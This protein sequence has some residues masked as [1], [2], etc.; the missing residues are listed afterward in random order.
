MQ[1]KRFSAR[2]SGWFGGR[3][4]ESELSEE[5]RSHIAIQTEENLAGGMSAAEARR[6]A[7][8]AFGSVALA[9]ETSREAWRFPRVDSFAADLKF[10]C[11]MLWKAPGFTVVALL[12]LALG[13]AANTALFTVVNGVLL[14][15]L[16]FPHPEQL[17]TLDASKPN[18]PRG[19]ISYPNFVDWQSRNRTFSAMALS[20]GTSFTFSA[21]GEPERLRG[22]WITADYFSLLGVQPVIGRNLMEGEDTIGGP[23]IALISEALWRRKLGASAEVLGSVITLDGGRYSVVG[24][25]PASFE[26]MQVNFAPPEVYLPMGTWPTGALRLR[27]AGLGLHGIGRLKPGVTIEQARRDMERVTR[28]LSAEFPDVDRGLGATLLPLQE[29]L[30]GGVRATL[31]FLF[32]AVGFVLLIACVNVASLMLARSAARTREFAVR[33]ALGASRSRVIRQLLTEALLLAVAGG[34]LGVAFASWLTRAAM[35]LLPQA[36]PRMQQVRMDGYVLAFAAAASGV[37]AVLFGLGPAFRMAAPPMQ[38][39]L[40]TGRGSGGR[41]LRT[42]RGLIVVEVATALLLLVGAGLSLR[43]LMRL[44]KVDPGFNSQ[45]VLLLNVDLPPA[46]RTAPDAAVYAAWRDIHRSLNSTPGVTAASL[47]DGS[48][49]FGGDDE[50]L[51]WHG[52]EPHP[53]SASEMNWALRYDVTPEYLRT[54]GLPLL[55]GR[56]FTPQEDRKSPITVVVDDVFAATFFPGQDAIGK[57]IQWDGLYGPGQESAKPLREAEIVGVVGH[58]KHWGLDTDDKQQLRAQAYLNIWQTEQHG[59]SSNYGITLRTASAP[60]SVIPALRQ[61]LRQVNGEAVVYGFRT[62]DNVIEQSLRTRRFT[63]VLLA[64]FAAIALLL[65]AIGIYGVISYLVRERTQEIGVRMALGAQRSTVLRMVLGEG[66]RL[67]GLG[68]L[69]GIVAA[70]PGAQAIRAQLFGTSPADPLTFV[71]VTGILLAVALAASFIPAYRAT[72]ID[73][74]QALRSE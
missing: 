10:G 48:T 27:A 1:W 46:M 57:R 58:V 14:Q 45:N 60:D 43:S 21:N 31:V 25:V 20:R 3:Q 32:V 24:V 5:I 36:L 38:A 65:A 34:A 49:P 73:P 47:R 7:M 54:M 51:F 74:M 17:C 72:A 62:M 39:G 55:R 30:V 71:A 66:A 9:K 23:H 15:P 16:P 8:A 70:I 11:R 29:S 35:A 69:L 59:M 42:H 44:W 33:A 41:R 67:T 52:G 22:A 37:S 18:F 64:A 28:E 26:L 68:L 19:S 53:Q 56:F 4:R 50:L 12:T 63:M 13:I 61:N 40:A 6:S 2:L